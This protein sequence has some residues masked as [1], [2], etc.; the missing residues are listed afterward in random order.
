MHDTTEDH[1]DEY[2]AS[3]EEQVEVKVLME[4][5]APR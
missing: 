4:I 2:D 1:E 3:S 5:S